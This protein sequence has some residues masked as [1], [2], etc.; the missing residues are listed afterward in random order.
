MAKESLARIMYG[1]SEDVHV[2]RRGSA[3]PGHSSPS[4]TENASESAA[5]EET[6]GELLHR[7]WVNVTGKS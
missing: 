3:L 5:A 4:L 2:S 7:V 1:T 6:L